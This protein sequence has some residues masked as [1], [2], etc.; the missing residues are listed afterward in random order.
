MEKT[1]RNKKLNLKKQ[2]IVLYIIA[3]IIACIVPFAISSRV[4]AQKIGSRLGEEA[5]YSAGKFAGSFEA[6]SDY[7]KAYEEGKAEG[8]L[9]ANDIT[10][11][12]ANSIKELEKLEVLA[13][14]VKLYDVHSAGRE[15]KNDYKALYLLK[16]EAVFTVDLSQAEIKKEG[17]TL[18]IQLPLPEAELTINQ[19]EIEKIAEYQRKFFNGSAEE[20]FDAY[21]NSMKK[22]DT[23][24][25]ETI[26]NYDSMMISAKESAKKQVAQLVSNVTVSQNGTNVE[27]SF[28]GE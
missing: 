22:I 2:E 9:S 28:S 5:G 24:T 26:A 18:Y 21:L 17:N 6:F 23:A 1:K 11:E 19:E 7:D 14:S 10:E 25:E 16:G 12:V 20:G 13:A 15:G 4:R 3:A 27:I 8:G